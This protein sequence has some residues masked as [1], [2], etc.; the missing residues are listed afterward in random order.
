MPCYVA[1]LLRAL[2][3]NRGLHYRQRSL[4][5]STNRVINIDTYYN[6][7]LAKDYFVLFKYKVMLLSPG[8]ILFISLDWKTTFSYSIFP[9]WQ[10]TKFH[11][12]KK[13]ISNTTDPLWTD[14][15]DDGEEG[16]EKKLKAPSGDFQIE[17][18]KPSSSSSTTMDQCYK[19][20]GYLRED[21]VCRTYKCYK[22]IVR[23]NR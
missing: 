6:L 12:V 19:V 7:G 1:V 11:F 16:P 22:I 14:D 18:E 5:I 8:S 10:Q 2:S 4:L 13:R 21:L 15:I 17:R 23:R 9:T 3:N 20:V